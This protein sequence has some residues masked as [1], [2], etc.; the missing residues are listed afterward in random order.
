MLDPGGTVAEIHGMRAVIHLVADTEGGFVTVGSADKPDIARD[1]YGMPVDQSPVGAKLV[2]RHAVQRRVEQL[3]LPPVLLVFHQRKEIRE[4]VLDA[5]EVHL[6]QHDERDGIRIQAGAVQC[7]RELARGICP[8]ELVVVAEQFV[9][10]APGGFHLHNFAVAHQRLAHDLRQAG[11]ARSAHALQ[12]GQARCA[13]PRD[14]IRNLLL[15]V[16]QMQAAVPGIRHHE[17][18]HALQRRRRKRLL[19][20]HI[21]IGGKATPPA[22]QL[23]ERRAGVEIRLFRIRRAD[24]FPGGRPRTPPLRPG[25]FALVPAHGRQNQQD[26]QQKHPDQ[27]RVNGIAGQFVR[28]LRQVRR[29]LIRQ[30]HEDKLLVQPLHH[31]KILTADADQQNRRHIRGDTRH[32]EPRK[33]PGSAEKCRDRHKQEHHRQRKQQ[34]DKESHLVVCLAE[35]SVGLE[36]AD[37]VDAPDKR[38]EAARIAHRDK[39]GQQGG[40]GQH[41][42]NDLKAQQYILPRPSGSAVCRVRFGKADS[43]HAG[44]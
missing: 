25:T 37:A 34:H 19:P 36:Q 40:A 41:A 8:A 5:R 9:L 4:V 29:Q 27:H 7:L 10:V 43:L 1:A 21:G 24:C 33:E 38:A 17:T 20:P 15:T 12:D 13:Q 18:H 31:L 14:E 22:V 2:I 32:A 44:G 26:A 16:G 42:E 23:R 28:D 30:E 35:R 11:L 39:I 3:Q 6:I